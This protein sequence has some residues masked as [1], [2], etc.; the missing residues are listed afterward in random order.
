M[1]QWMRERHVI[2]RKMLLREVDEEIRIW[3]KT[4]AKPGAHEVFVAAT[5][6]RLRA[7]DGGFNG[8][9]TRV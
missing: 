7:S 1:D 2:R 4:C 3:P 5:R 8:I 9:R 6:E